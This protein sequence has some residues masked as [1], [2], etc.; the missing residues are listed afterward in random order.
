MRTAVQNWGLEGAIVP[1]HVCTPLPLLNKHSV[2]EKP[3]FQYNVPQILHTSM[4]AEGHKIANEGHS[5]EG[6]RE[7]LG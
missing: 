1:P 4:S 3:M 6:E 7:I 5:S 2:A